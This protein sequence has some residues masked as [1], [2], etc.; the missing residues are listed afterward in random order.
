MDNQTEPATRRTGQWATVRLTPAERAAL[1]ARAG[2]R[3]G[4]ISNAL[5]QAIKMYCEA[6]EPGQP[7]QPMTL[8]ER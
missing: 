1:I 5:R 4:A 7:G 3:Q 6:S 8:T 2:T